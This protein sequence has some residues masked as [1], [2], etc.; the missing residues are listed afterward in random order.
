LEALE[1]KRLL[2]VA[3]L[4]L[5]LSAGVEAQETPKIPKWELFGG[6]SEYLA[7][8][9]IPG[10]RQ[11]PSNGVQVSV[12]R[13]VTNYFRITG[14]FNTQFADHV[15]NLAPLP[16]GGKHVNSKEL[17]GVF[18]PEATYRGLRKFDIF[19]HFLIG[20]AYGRDNT[21][22]KTPTA[23]YTTWIYGLGGGIDYKLAKRVSIRLMEFDWMTTHFPIN[24]PEAQDDWRLN[25]GF[26][27]HFGN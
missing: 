6:Y 18:G 21:D 11:L 20:V 4:A 15:V 22:P 7:G 27:F 23:S 16:L 25:T 8:G 2:S 13:V 14:Q 10:E 24:S 5:A 12:Y 26:V 9:G 19:G 1:L 17:L 3:L